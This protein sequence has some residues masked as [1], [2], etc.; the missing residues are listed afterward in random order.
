MKKNNDNKI[1][2][3]FTI[4][5]LLFAI[6]IMVVALFALSKLKNSTLMAT[7]SAQRVT[8]A[9][10]CAEQIL[11]ELEEIVYQS[12]LSS[13]PVGNSSGD[14]GDNRYI[15]TKNVNKID[16]MNLKVVEVSVNWSKYNVTVRSILRSK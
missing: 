14:C 12:S 7:I 16:D 8:E 11:E 1:V 9:T 10:I 6:L 3:G 5:E 2:E 15:W 13:I 4:L